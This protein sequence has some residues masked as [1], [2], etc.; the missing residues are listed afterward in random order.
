[1]LVSTFA[2]IY[3][4]EAGDD[5]E[6]VP[7]IEAM[8]NDR[9]PDGTPVYNI[10]SAISLMVFFVFSAQCMATFAIVKRET[11]SWRWPLVMMLYMTTLAYIAS[12]IV[13]QGGKLL[14]WG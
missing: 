11:N 7:L 9:R 6:V 12:L 5:A 4:I 14:G 10:L 13:Y 8:R 3:N 2:T 1:M